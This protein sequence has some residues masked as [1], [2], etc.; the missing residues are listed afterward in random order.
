MKKPDI[1]FLKKLL[2]FTS[3]TEIQRM[4]E[5]SDRFDLSSTEGEELELFF[6]KAGQHIGSLYDAMVGILEA[7][8]FDLDNILFN[9]RLL[10]KLSAEKRGVSTMMEEFFV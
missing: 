1:I 3:E 7:Y 4:I 9:T 6:I 8:D 10:E 2:E 5:L